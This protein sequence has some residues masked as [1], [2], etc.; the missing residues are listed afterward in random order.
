MF[1][2]FNNY[3]S[4]NITF[5]RKQPTLKVNRHILE[6]GFEPFGDIRH[7]FLRK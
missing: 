6:V 2:P 4:K 1:V 7:R 5:W 3:S